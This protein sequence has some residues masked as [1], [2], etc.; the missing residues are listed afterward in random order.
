[1]LGRHLRGRSGADWLLPGRGPG[2]LP[3]IP[4]GLF[5]HHGQVAKSEAN[6]I[7]K[8]RKMRV[9]ETVVY[10]IVQFAVAQVPGG[11]RLQP[12]PDRLLRSAGHPYA[13]RQ[14]HHGQLRPGGAGRAE[15]LRGGGREGLG[16]VQVRMRRPVLRGCGRGRRQ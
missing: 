1:M 8:D 15:S 9:R 4:G 2:R 16:P 11:D 3:G 13:L 10:F 6:L 12:E 7:K 14:E 5:N